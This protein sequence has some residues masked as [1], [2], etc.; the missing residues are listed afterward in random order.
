[1]DDLLLHAASLGLRVKFRDL[2]RRHGEIHSS[3]LII[4]NSERSLQAKRITLAH[5][6]GHRVHGHDWTTARHDRAADERA[7]ETYA[8]RLLVSEAEFRR[9]ENCVGG[10]IYALA[11]EL[12]LTPDHV[13]L[14]QES[15]QRERYEAHRV[16]ERHLRLA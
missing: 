10:N 7:A 4:V 1:M 12:N 11:K 15:Y 14:W 13:A 5:E 2:G 8:V 16:R 6:I 3:G 9:A